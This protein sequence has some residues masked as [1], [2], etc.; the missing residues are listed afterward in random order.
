MYL[1]FFF[2]YYWCRCFLYRPKTQSVQLCLSATKMEPNPKKQ[3]A[4][5][6]A[7][8]IFTFL[9]TKPTNRFIFL[10]LP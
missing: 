8:G 9:T 2:M 3:L 7:V 5:P 6:V 1:L 4:L 10:S